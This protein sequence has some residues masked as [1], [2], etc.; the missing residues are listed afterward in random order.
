MDTTATR[1][2]PATELKEGDRFVKRQCPGDDPR[3]QFAWS[4]I[5]TSVSTFNDTVVEVWYRPEV[6]DGEF[7]CESW[8]TDET[9]T[10]LG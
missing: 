8:T 7:L 5:A 2:I 9:V 10:V 3:T 4:D 6:L 1:T